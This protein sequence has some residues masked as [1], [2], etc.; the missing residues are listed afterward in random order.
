MSLQPTC[1]IPIYRLITS[2]MIS[3]TISCIIIVVLLLQRQIDQ[4][5]YTSDQIRNK[6][7]DESNLLP[8]VG[9]M[10]MPE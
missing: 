2:S 7:N 8:I 10:L 5:C 1:N 9:L 4:I 3:Q 6:M